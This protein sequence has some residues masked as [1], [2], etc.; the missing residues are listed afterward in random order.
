MDSPLGICLKTAQDQKADCYRLTHA[1]LPELAKTRPHREQQPRNKD[2]ITTKHGS[3]K[4]P[5]N[6]ET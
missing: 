6:K 2:W 5:L 1:P 3:N 4:N